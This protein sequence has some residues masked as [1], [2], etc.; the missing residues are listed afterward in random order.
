MLHG[1]A[2]ELWWLVAAPVLGL[3]LIGLFLTRFRAHM[4]LVCVYLH[5]H[6]ILVFIMN[7]HSLL[8]HASVLG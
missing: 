1:P 7:K 6:S 4:Q 5:K 3:N 8:A 2:W